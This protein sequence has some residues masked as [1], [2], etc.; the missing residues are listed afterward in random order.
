MRIVAGRFSGR[1]LRSPEDRTVRPTGEKVRQA[2]FN[3]LQHGD[4]PVLNGARVADLFAGSGALG[5][6]ALS[7]GAGH[8]LFV[9]RSPKSLRLLQQ[10]IAALGA[11][12]ACH[13][14]RKDAAALPSA[15]DPFDIVFLDPPYRKALAAPALSALLQR[16]WL[17]ADAAL[18][19]ESAADEEDAVPAALRVVDDRVY[20]ETR[21]R[22]LKRGA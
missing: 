15:T 17:A 12:D 8:V 5:L 13:V 22:F 21:L 7:R 16:G 11:E 2:L 18:I 3:I 19:W 6:E 10:N 14:L 9:E 1:R 20:G 4:Y